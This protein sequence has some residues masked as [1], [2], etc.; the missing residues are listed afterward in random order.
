M[1]VIVKRNIWTDPEVQCM[2]D[3]MRDKK[4]LSLLDGKKYKNKNIYIM[5]EK[6]MNNFGF[7]NKSAEQ[8]ILKWRKLKAEYIKTVNKNKISGTGRST[9]PFYD[10]LNEILAIRP[11]ASF[12]GVDTSNNGKILALFIS[13]HT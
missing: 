8:I 10:E 12:V 3:I 6:E 2:L 4:V 9:C 5:I 1:S 13:L 7:K 11:S